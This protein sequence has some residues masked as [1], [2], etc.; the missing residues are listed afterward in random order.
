MRS[1]VE[2]H[3]S[4]GYEAGPM[5]QRYHAEGYVLQSFLRV[6]RCAPGG[7]QYV[8]LCVEYV[9]LTPRCSVI[10]FY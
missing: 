6:V 4:A 3:S 1:V 10:S 2:L 9:L 7:G 8:R 5:F